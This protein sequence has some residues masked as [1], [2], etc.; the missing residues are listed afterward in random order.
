MCLSTRA[1]TYTCTGL[2]TGAIMLPLEVYAI[3]M[4]TRTCVVTVQ[5]YK[6]FCVATVHKSLCFTCTCLSTRAIVLHLDLSV[7][8][9]LC[10]T[11]MCVFLCCTCMRLS[12]RACAAA[13]VVGSTNFF[14]IVLGLLCKVIYRHY[15]HVYVL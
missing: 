10:C 11:C 12:T 2:S 8:K 4:S 13:G 5:L 6:C 9:S 3:C 7:Y 15:P 1:C 14:Y